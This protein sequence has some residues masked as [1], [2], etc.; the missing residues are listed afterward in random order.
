MSVKITEKGK[1]NANAYNR[2]VI[3][4]VD[5]GF[6]VKVSGSKLSDEYIS[7]SYKLSDSLREISDNEKII[8][9]VNS[10]LENAKISSIELGASCMG[11]SGEFIK[12]GNERQLYLQINN[13]ELLKIIIRMIKG[14]YD[15]DRYEYCNNVN[16]NNS[17]SIFLK[18]NVSSYDREFVSC[19]DCTLSEINNNC[20]DCPKNVR[21]KLLYGNG[22]IAK[23]DRMFIERFIYD[24]L[25]EEGIEASILEE[26]E[27][28]KLIDGVTKVGEY[29]DSYCIV[30]GDLSIKFNCTAFSRA[31]IFDFCNNIVNRYNK[32][33]IESR[34]NVMKR[35]LKMEGF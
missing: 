8:F 23:F 17:Y 2:I 35:Q 10:F 33:L 4:E 25:W 32:E 7:V 18:S 12:I 22:K 19:S 34:E 1:L 21:F 31:Y 28:I 30:C 11:C 6:S 14:K 20:Q 13:P 29:V 26:T 16:F 27:D 3:R 9:I 24:K 15:R 5:D